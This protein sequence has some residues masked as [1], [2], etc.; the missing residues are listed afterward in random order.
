MTTRKQT[1]YC[2]FYR[3]VLAYDNFTNLLYESVNVVGHP[4][5][6]CGNSA[7]RKQDMQPVAGVGDCGRLPQD[8]A[9]LDI[10]ALD[11]GEAG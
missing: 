10:V 5:I 9:L 4:E 8:R 2:E 1:G 6:I 3:L 11:G 7:L